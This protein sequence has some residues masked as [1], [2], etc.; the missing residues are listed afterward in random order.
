MRLAEWLVE[1]G[2]GETR[3]ALVEDGYILE[4]RIDRNDGRVRAEAR[5][6]YNA[7]GH[8]T[9]ENALDYYLLIQPEFA[10][11]EVQGR[12]RAHPAPGRRTIKLAVR[13]NTNVATVMRRIVRWSS[14]D[15]AV[16]KAQIR[17]IRMPDRKLSHHRMF[18]PAAVF[19]DA[20]EVFLFE[21]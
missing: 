6:P 15:R 2:I 8:R 13:E 18:D 7:H 20:I 4:A 5:C 3:A 14:E 10:F 16:E 11:R 12:A 17:F 1:A 19:D 21:C 9:A